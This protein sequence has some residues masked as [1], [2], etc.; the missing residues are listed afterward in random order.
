[1]FDIVFIS[2]NEPNADVNWYK[3][4]SQFS[5]ARRVHGVK[6]IHKAHIIAAKTSLTDMVWVVDGD[7]QVV[8][9]FNFEHPKGLWRESVYVYR[10]LN[11]VNELSYGYGGI[12]LLPRLKT[13]NMSFNSVDM[14]TSISEHFTAVDC[15]ASATYFNTDPFNAWKSAFRECVKLSSKIIDGQVSSESEQRLDTWCTVGA[16]IQY[17]VDTIQGALAGR[18]YGTLHK[19][20]PEALKLINNFEWLK[21]YYGN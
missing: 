1:M 2:Y 20:N 5:Y 16:G 8:N 15:I 14:T 19:N 18:A 4:K 17:G 10:A 9:D 3:L 7:S 6:G 13:I 21:Q 11:P 12:K